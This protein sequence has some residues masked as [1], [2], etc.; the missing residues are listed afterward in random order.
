MV[1]AALV[2]GGRVSLFD[3]K[4][5]DIGPFAT[6]SFDD[7]SGDTAKATS[8]KFSSDGNFLLLSGGSDK[9]F[10][11]GSFHGHLLQVPLLPPRDPA[12]ATPANDARLR[13]A[14]A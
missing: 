9:V 13:R 1:F 8:V 6:F 2:D 5:H 12:A 10:V 7:F 11:V 3:V 4:K 14:L